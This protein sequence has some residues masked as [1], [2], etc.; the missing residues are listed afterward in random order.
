MSG[1]CAATRQTRDAD[2]G[3]GGGH[4]EQ[5]LKDRAAAMQHRREDYGDQDRAGGLDRGSAPIR[6]A[7]R[8]DLRVAERYQ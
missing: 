7:P 6:A 8:A 2:G 5:H 3:C 4:S 1:T